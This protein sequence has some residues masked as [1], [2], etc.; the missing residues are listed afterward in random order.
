[1]NAEKRLKIL[2]CNSMRNTFFMKYWRIN[3]MILFSHIVPKGS[4]NGARVQGVNYIYPSSL[5]TINH[6]LISIK[7]SNNLCY[8]PKNRSLIS[9]TSTLLS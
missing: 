5:K 8:T 9:T 6:H 4:P 3:K 7:T 2:T 1:M